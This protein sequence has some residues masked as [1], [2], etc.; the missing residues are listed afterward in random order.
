MAVRRPHLFE[1]VAAVLAVLAL[2][3]D[4][5]FLVT[6]PHPLV[7]L[8]AVLVSAFGFAAVRWSPAVAV[9]LVAAA[10]I[11]AALG[12]SDPTGTWNVAL[13]TAFVVTARGLPA[14]PVALVVG[15]ANF[16]AVGLS[17]DG[18]TLDHPVPSIAAVA[19]VAAAAAGSAVR[20]QR[21][22]WAELAHSTREALSG[23]DAAVRQQVA[24][25]RLRIARD[26]HDT[27]GH[28]IAVVSMHLGAAEVQV[29][30]GSPARDHLEAAHSGVR[31]LLNETQEILQLLRRDDDGTTDG[32]SHTRI[33]E[34]V[35]TVRAAGVDLE[36][37]LDDSDAPLPPQTSAAAYRITQEALTN[38]QRH[39]TGRIEL[40]V[41][42]AGDTVTVET[43]NARAAAG[44]PAGVDDRPTGGGYGL[45]GMRERATAAGG[46][47]DVAADDRT[48]TLRAVLPAGAGPS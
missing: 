4:A 41:I 7:Q 29:P 1:T 25:E 15:A 22:Y 20:G 10:P 36:A 35:E 39:G 40:R 12:D 9:V 2:A 38:A 37:V 14:V 18:V 42:R 46:R 30:V 32:A 17:V 5:A 6:H 3:A 16:T 23:R 33:P 34:L 47:L 31:S 21:A 27:V 45:V 48:F 13:F 24:E 44:G 26:L 28:E 11:L 8:A 19:A 43:R